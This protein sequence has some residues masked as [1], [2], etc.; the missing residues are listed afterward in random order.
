MDQYSNP[1][2]RRRRRGPRRAIAA[3]WL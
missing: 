1:P 2:A 3:V